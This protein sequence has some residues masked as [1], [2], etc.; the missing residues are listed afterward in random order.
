MK[1]TLPMATLSAG[2]TL[3]S[4]AGCSDSLATT[5]GSTA[6]ASSAQ[7]STARNSN[8]NVPP[9]PP[10]APSA[11]TI[12]R[13]DPAVKSRG[14]VKAS[15]VPLQIPLQV[16]WN[17][18]SM[19]FSNPTAFA[20]DQP[21]SVLSCFGYNAATGA[22]VKQAFSQAGFTRQAGAP[23]NQYQGYWVFCSAPVLLTLNGSN[24]AQLPL[25]TNLVSGWNLVGTPISG[26]VAS[27]AL[28]FNSQSLAA[29]STGGLLGKQAFTYSPTDGAYHA[30][31]YQ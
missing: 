16:G 19:P 25:Q 15:S 2:L 12:A 7:G 5:T 8:P 10:S 14:T 18:F 31:S 11:G 24:S 21:A 22:Y 6:Q 26:A 1:K 13:V 20:V 3:M 29:A 23:P 27:S 28:S 4:V 9:P 30:L 17:L